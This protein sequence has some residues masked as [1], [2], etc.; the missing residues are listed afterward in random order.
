[1]PFRHGA[2]DNK[3]E[4]IAALAASR[5]AVYE[6]LK[7]ARPGD[8][9]LIQQRARYLAWLGRWDDALAAYDAMIHDH[10]DA[11][12]AFVEYASILLLKGD[13]D[14]YRKW[15]ARLA[16]KF[17]STP[18]YFVGTML[19]RACALS[20]HAGI[21]APQVIEW[22]EKAAAR[23]PRDR[24]ALHAMGLALLRAGRPREAVAQFLSSIAAGEDSARNWI[25]LALAGFRAGQQAEASRWLEKA[26][27]WLEEKQ[28]ESG[29][30]TT[31]LSPPIYITDWLETL[32]LCREADALLEN[33]KLG[34]V[35][36][37][38]ARRLAF[39]PARQ[40]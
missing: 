15:C 39:E 17:A 18:G 8:S 7:K 23:A 5:D 13:V 22:A 9:L 28:L 37:R 1:V 25:G 29:D 2:W 4:A 20:A 11:E 36:I 3:C 10:P 32:V 30:R 40:V 33:R 26:G 19:A 24:R 35:R 34:N 31:H 14:G 21:V 6:R 38:M 27:G 16:Q 12:D